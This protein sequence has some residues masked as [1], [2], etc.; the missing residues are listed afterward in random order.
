MGLAQAG[1]PTSQ[2]ADQTPNPV[3]PDL[4]A[5]GLFPL[6]VWISANR[7]VIAKQKSAVTQRLEERQASRVSRAT[8]GPLA[9]PMRTPEAGSIAPLETRP[10]TSMSSLLESG[11][12]ENIFDVRS[13]SPTPSD[14]T[15]RG[16]WDSMNMFAAGGLMPSPMSVRQPSMFSDPILGY[17]IQDTQ[18]YP[19]QQ[20]LH[21]SLSLEP[22]QQPR[23]DW[24]V[25]PAVPHLFDPLYR[26]APPLPLQWTPGYHPYPQ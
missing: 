9:L 13:I 26:A 23:Q 7:V 18:Q 19:Q 11:N 20:L 21:L 16:C 3:R 8:R 14:A 17:P 2:G 6:D 15:L 24:P 1:N 12:F 10:E 5:P 4:A 25:F 22:P